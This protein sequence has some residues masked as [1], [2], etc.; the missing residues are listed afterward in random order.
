VTK[1]KCEGNVQFSKNFF[2]NLGSS[3]K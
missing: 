3:V 2:K 1:I